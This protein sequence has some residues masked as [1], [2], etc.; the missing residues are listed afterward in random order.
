LAVAAFFITEHVP[1]QSPFDVDAPKIVLTFIHI[2]SIAGT[3]FFL[4]TVVVIF[5]FDITKVKKALAEEHK[6]SE[7][8][9]LNILPEPIATRLKTSQQTIADGF[10]NCSILFA[11]IVDFTKFSEGIPPPN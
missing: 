8:L 2:F 6:R 5:S 7:S 1:F 10:D 3:L 11:D 4:T 9:L